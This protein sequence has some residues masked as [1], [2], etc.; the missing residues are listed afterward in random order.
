MR[1]V[2]SGGAICSVRHGRQLICVA[3]LDIAGCAGAFSL[4]VQPQFYCISEKLAAVWAAVFVWLLVLYVSVRGI[5]QHSV[6]EQELR[7]R[8]AGWLGALPWHS[9]DH[10]ATG[11]LPAVLGAAGIPAAALILEVRWSPFV[12]LLT[13]P[14]GQSS[15]T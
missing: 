14:H 11:S 5:E 13:H 2:L 12:H 10:V 8:S 6:I 3:Y 9:N 1:G 15:P 4:G 7:V